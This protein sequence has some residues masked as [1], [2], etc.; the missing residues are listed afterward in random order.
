MRTSGRFI[1]QA[2]QVVHDMELPANTLRRRAALK[3]E[4]DR[5]ARLRD[6]EQARLA[7]ASDHTVGEIHG[8]VVEGRDNR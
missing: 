6:L 8:S 4:A 2:N 3:A 5:R 1:P 7:L